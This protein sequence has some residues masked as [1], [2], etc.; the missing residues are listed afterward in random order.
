MDNKLKTGLI[1]LV[2]LVGGYSFLTKPFNKGFE[3]DTFM[4]SGGKKRPVAMRANRI[5]GLPPTKDYITNA[6]LTDMLN[7]LYVS[8]TKSWPSYGDMNREAILHLDKDE[9]EFYSNSMREGKLQNSN[10]KQ[11]SYQINLLNGALIHVK[12]AKNAQILK[13]KS[14]IYVA[15]CRRLAITLEDLKAKGI[16][17]NTDDGCLRDL[18]AVHDFIANF[19]IPGVKFKTLKGPNN[20][21][22]SATFTKADDIH[23]FG[24]YFLPNVASNDM[25]AAVDYYLG[26]APIVFIVSHRG[27]S[28]IKELSLSKSELIE[29]KDYMVENGYIKQYFNVLNW[30]KFLSNNPSILYIGMADYEHKFYNIDILDSA[31][32]SQIRGDVLISKRWDNELMSQIF[33]DVE[34][35]NMS[36]TVMDKLEVIFNKVAKG[37]GVAVNQ[38]ETLEASIKESN[39][40]ALIEGLNAYFTNPSRQKN[41]KLRTEYI[42]LLQNDDQFGRFRASIMGDF[43]EVHTNREDGTYY[44]K[45]VDS[46]YLLGSGLEPYGIDFKNDITVSKD[47]IVAAKRDYRKQMSRLIDLGE[48]AYQREKKNRKILK[49]RYT[50]GMTRF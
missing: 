22:N 50:M 6:K 32:Y 37:M 9:Q 4:A 35:N 36:K 11:Y 46:L 20:T 12:M 48:T 19:K 39:K 21:I 49:E 2:A 28:T 42:S 17:Y 23:T 18:K 33:T 13:I 34:F 24:K 43:K 47:F 5:N 7:D 44:I 41:P 14:K 16:N 27:D 40:I 30:I 10:N 26:S 38:K 15:L 8:V 45:D 25:L 29:V 3:A 31:I 1:S